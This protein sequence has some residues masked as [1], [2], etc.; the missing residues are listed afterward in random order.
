MSGLEKTGRPLHVLL[1]NQAFHPDVVSTAQM[2]KDLADALAKRGH[3]VTAVASRS[4]YG[5][6][7]AV[8]A[9][10]EA[11]S[12][13]GAPFPIQARRVGANLF[14]KRGTLARLADFALFYLLAMVKVLTLA[15]PDVVIGFTTPPYIALVGV[16][17]KWLRGSR[18]VHW[19]M[20]LYPDTP[21]A[22][23]MM[24]ADSVLTRVLESVNRFL[25]RRSG[26]SVVLGRCMLKRV[27]DKGIAP[28]KVTMIPVWADL[29]GI[30]P[31]E[32]AANP[33][34]KEWAAADDFVVM[35]SGN[36]GIGHDAKAILGAMLRLKGETGIR[37]IFVGGGKRRAEVEA[38][39]K[40]YSLPNV[41]WKEYQPR[42]ALANSLSAADVHL[43][44]L[45][46][47][48]EGVMVPSKVFGIMAAGRASVFV[49]N[50]SSEVALVL[51]EA[52]AG[53]IVN[54]G[55]DEGLAKI[56]LN[57][58]ANPERRRAL[59]ENAR[60]G[61]AGKYDRDTACRAWVAL[62]EKSGQ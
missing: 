56:I 32:H 15:K 7:G 16:V 21:V 3:K 5:Q 13:E 54:P 1:L 46:D 59:G 34:R 45:R 23:G 37:F 49:G 61:V 14:G 51:V 50:A 24:R 60:R 52:D 44:S 22:C 10:E 57:L 58:R 12:V 18:A 20:D 26:V 42:E 35:Y 55:N 36:F 31:V 62:V 28:A 8:L 17:C 38:F 27:L 33:L 43:I 53:V 6:A 41:S 11:I 39:V 2:A 4:I 48:A 47:G 40:E 30:E 25:L 19:V 9:S 29:S